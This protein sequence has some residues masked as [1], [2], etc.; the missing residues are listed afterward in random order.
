MKSYKIINKFAF[1]F[2]R[3]SKAHIS[4]LEGSVMVETQDFNLVDWGLSSMSFTQ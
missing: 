3:S 4:R 2:K 1:A